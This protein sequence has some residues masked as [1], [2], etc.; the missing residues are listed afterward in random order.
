LPYVECDA[1]GL[2]PRPEL[3]RQ[4]DVKRY[5]TWV[6]KGERHEG[7]LTLDRLAELSGYPGTAPLG[8]K[9]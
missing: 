9:R 7:I 3:C 2:D 6:I 1:K 4:L 8:N 5:P